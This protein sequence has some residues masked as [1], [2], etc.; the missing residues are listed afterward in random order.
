MRTRGERVR[1]A[2]VSRLQGVRSGRVAL[3]LLVS[4]SGGPGRRRV[5][6]RHLQV[7]RRVVLHAAQPCLLQWQELRAVPRRQGP[8][9]EGSARQAQPVDAHPDNA[10]GRHPPLRRRQGRLQCFG[11][12]YIFLNKIILEFCCVFETEFL[13]L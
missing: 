8:R 11:G 5:H 12:Q 3:G 1:S 4:V 7:P 10:A 2:A 9:Q 13:Q 6:H